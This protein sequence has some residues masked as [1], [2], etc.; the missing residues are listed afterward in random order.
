MPVSVDDASGCLGLSQLE[1][2]E[3]VDEFALCQESLSDTFCDLCRFAHD[4]RDGRHFAA[5]IGAEDAPYRQIKSEHSCSE[6][7]EIRW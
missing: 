5:R 4:Q 6:E 2:L 3:M 7:P 1:L